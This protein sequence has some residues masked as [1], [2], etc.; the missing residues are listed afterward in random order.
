VAVGGGGSRHRRWRRAALGLAA[1]GVRD[2]AR[3][4]VRGLG[5][6]VRDCWGQSPLP[7]T[8][9]RRWGVKGSPAVEADCGAGRSAAGMPP[10]GVGGWTS[11][12][13]GTGAGAAT[14]FL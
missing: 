7:A 10:A 12:G 11:G 2:R 6:R 13:P 14:T 9:E 3:V 5:F 1:D 4:R 8:L